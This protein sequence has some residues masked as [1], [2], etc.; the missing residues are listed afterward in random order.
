MKWENDTEGPGQNLQRTL[1]FQDSYDLCEKFTLGLGQEAGF[2]SWLSI[3]KTNNKKQK[4]KHLY[5][6]HSG[7]GESL[8]PMSS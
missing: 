8:G 3:L 4:T 6:L 2:E 7:I 5:V 1:H